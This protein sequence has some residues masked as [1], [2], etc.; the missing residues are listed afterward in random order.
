MGVLDFLEYKKGFDPVR[1]SIILVNKLLNNGCGIKDF[2][3]PERA[4]EV[5]NYLTPMLSF[6]SG[7]PYFGA[8][9]VRESSVNVF[10]FNRPLSEEA[11]EALLARSRSLWN[12]KVQEERRQRQ[13]WRQNQKYRKKNKKSTWVHRSHSAEKK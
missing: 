10:T 3:T 1:E 5:I 8:C 7:Q 11:E 12:Q 13:P 4:A 9:I 2:K 6:V